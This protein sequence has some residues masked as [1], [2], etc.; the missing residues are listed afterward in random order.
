MARTGKEVARARRARIRARDRRRR[1]REAREGARLLPGLSRRAGEEA[2]EK[3]VVPPAAR[4]KSVLVLAV[5]LCALA[6]PFA[7][8]AGA[9]L[10][11]WVFPAPSPAPVLVAP[12]DGIT[13]TLQGHIEG[14][15]PFMLTQTLNATVG[16][17]SL[18]PGLESA[19]MGLE[20]G[21]NFSIVVP[22]ADAYG[23]WNASRLTYIQR[24]EENPR[25]HQLTTTAFQRAYGTPYV[26]E[27][28]ATQPW[29][30]TVLSI[31]SGNVLMRYEPTLNQEVS[32]Y[33]YW[34]SQVVSFN[35]TTIVTE[36]ELFVGQSFQ[37]LS[38][39]TGSIIEVRVTAENATTFTLD[40]NPPLA[41]KTLHY[42]GTI[43]AVR[44]GPGLASSRAGGAVSLSSDSCE[45][46]HVGAGF[47]AIEG[48]GSA[49]RVGSSILVNLT[50]ED[51]W[52]HQVVG[53]RAEATAFNGSRPTASS[54]G[55][56]SSL[57][58]SG[59]GAAALTLS[60][61]GNATSI[62]VLI[63]ATAHHIH[64]SG[65]KPSD[66]PYQLAMRIPIGASR[67]AVVAPAPHPASLDLWVTLGRITGFAALGVA[68][69][70]AVQG[71]RR[72]LRR[73][74]HFKWPPWLT[75]HFSL[76]LFAT[77]LTAIHAVAFMSS[78]YRGVWT[79]DIVVGVVSLLALGTMG[80]T[81]IV[82]A[83][84][85]G[86]RAPGIRK[87]HYWLMLGMLFTGFLHT[88][89]SGTT[90]RMLFGG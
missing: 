57:E 67:G 37:I 6:L 86:L 70:S 42:G 60:G 16:D 90:V 11:G 66:L 33:L 35:N 39:K 65:G 82:L 23:P 78:T 52:Q 59:S 84:W 68:C 76:S 56:L 69:V 24:T 18:V 28:V 50:V 22:P 62:T 15:D 45:R 51:P 10:S 48:S 4:R 25:A 27:P 83:K 2:P 53:I 26:G 74:P 38:Q 79:W 63:N 20:A 32:L 19:L 9:D 64:A 8:F 47:Q 14:G 41:G 36:N 34:L 89:A 40:L 54:A 58:P 72:H 85:T 73:A 77:V 43:L 87:W 71:Y 29:P 21:D 80:V 17:G 49:Q 1:E 46:C 88:F 13:L 3:P 61:Q 44:P 30:S 7:L 31:P 5:S 75:F 81:G 55:S 12:G